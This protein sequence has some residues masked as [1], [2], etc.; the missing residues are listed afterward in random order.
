MQDVYDDKYLK[1]ENYMAVG[2]SFADDSVMYFILPDK[3]KD[4]DE[5]IT[6]DTINQVLASSQKGLGEKAQI[7]LKIPYFTVEDKFLLNDLN[8]KLGITKLLGGGDLSGISAE[9]GGIGEMKQD[10]KI[11][12]DEKGV[13]AAAVTTIVEASGIFEKE[14]LPKVEMICDR[15]FMYIIVKDNVPLFIGTVYNPAE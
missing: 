8:K 14:K 10:T 12:V 13:E 6:K 15:P 5:I 9:I 11:I 4:L 3:G 7:T 1:G 2:K